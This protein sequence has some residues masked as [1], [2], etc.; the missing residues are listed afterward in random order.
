MTSAE[1]EEFLGELNTNDIVK[2][3]YRRDGIW[4]GWAAMA[5]ITLASLVQEQ[6]DKGVSIEA[7]PTRKPIVQQPV[8]RPVRTTAPNSVFAFGRSF[9]G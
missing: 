1:L 2:G 3:L 6:V 5:T 4:F 9:A 8:V 7:R